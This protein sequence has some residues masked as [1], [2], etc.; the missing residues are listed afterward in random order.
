MGKEM[1]PRLIKSCDRSR[2]GAEMGLKHPSESYYLSISHRLRRLSTHN[3]GHGERWHVWGC[4]RRGPAPCRSPG[5][6]TGRHLEGCSRLG[7]F[8]DETQKLGHVSHHHRHPCPP[9]Q[10]DSLSG[11]DFLPQS[12]TAMVCKDTSSDMSS[13]WRGG[14]RQPPPIVAGRQPRDISKAVV[15]GGQHQESKL[16]SCMVPWANPELAGFC[17]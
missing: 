15:S 9:S 7:C 11:A 3:T 12:V 2:H 4:G 1:R 6:R 14:P 17:G 10:V 5:N 13:P 8:S 16:S